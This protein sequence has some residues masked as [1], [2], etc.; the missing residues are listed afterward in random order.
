[1]TLRDTSIQRPSHIDSYVHPL[2]KGDTI[3]ISN[4]LMKQDLRK[5]DHLPSTWLEMSA[6]V[7]TRALGNMT[8]RTSG[9]YLPTTIGKCILAIQGEFY[10]WDY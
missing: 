7:Y 9:Q 6:I 8:R 5:F 3:G 10:Y 4:F 1:M 2:A